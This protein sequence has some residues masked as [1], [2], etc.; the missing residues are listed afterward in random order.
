LQVKKT[1]EWSDSV[2]TEILKVKGDWQEVLDDCRSTIG[3]E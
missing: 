1:T 2:K 3:K